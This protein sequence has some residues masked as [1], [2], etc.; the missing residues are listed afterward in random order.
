MLGFLV[1]NRHRVLTKAEILY[2]IWPDIAVEE[3]NLTVQVSALRKALGLKVLVTI[4]GRSYQ[5]LL[6]VAEDAPVSEGVPQKNARACASIRSLS[7][8]RRV[9]RSGQSVSTAT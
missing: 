4:P 2:A 8:P 7:T 9:T 1:A 6:S 5:F 3:S